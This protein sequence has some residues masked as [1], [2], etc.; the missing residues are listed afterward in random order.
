MLNDTS[1]R[2]PRTS[3]TD[4]S[5]WPDPWDSWSGPTRPAPFYRWHRVIAGAAL[6]LSIVGTI[7]VLA[8][9]M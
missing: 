3:R 2:F 8:W 9:P 4:P 6:L 7:V 1:Q 5:A